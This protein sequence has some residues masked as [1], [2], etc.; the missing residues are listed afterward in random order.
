MKKNILSLCLLLI[1]L[2]L[3]ACAPKQAAVSEKPEQKDLSMETCETED[4]A[5]VPA[6]EEETIA[7]TPDISA[8][9]QTV[10]EPSEPVS[11]TINQSG[12]TAFFADSTDAPE[13][14]PFDLTLVSEKKNNI[15]DGADWFAGNRLYLPVA[16]GRLCESSNRIYEDSDI[17]Y[18][19]WQ[20]INATVFFDDNY[21]YQWS[22][23]NVIIFDKITAQTKYVIQVSSDHWSPMG[24][25]AYLEEGILYIGSIHNGYA[26][27]NS[28][29]L[30]A[31]DIENDRILWRS[32][33]QTYNS[34]G[35]IVKDGII[36]CGYGFTAEPDYIYQISMYTGKVL[37]KTPVAKMPDLLVEKNGQLYVHTY[38]YDYVFNME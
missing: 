9:S 23:E 15:S 31:Y 10:P 25:C 36:I 30:M 3:T 19:H 27:E 20:S 5:N 14:V 16:N 37:S 28:C 6:R 38:S 11:R 35:F 4:M 7:P 34:A 13:P 17:D 22:A 32:E 26:M 2:A 29:Y 8:E 1:I 12:L 18:D 33:D 24:S 21:I